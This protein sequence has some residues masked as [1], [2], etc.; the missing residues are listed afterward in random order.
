MQNYHEEE[1]IGKAYDSRLMKRLLAYA[2]PYRWAMF[3]AVV[4]LVIITLVD[5]AKPWLVRVAIDEH[6]NAGAYVGWQPGR[7]PAPGIRVKGKILIPENKVKDAS[8][9]RLPSHTL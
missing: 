8:G 7:E 6:I 5:L 2:K 9:N 1:V 3:L 4:L